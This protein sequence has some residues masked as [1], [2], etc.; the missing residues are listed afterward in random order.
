MIEW[1]NRPHF[2]DEGLEFTCTGCGQCCTGAPGVVFVNE[3]EI[4]DIAR[5]LGLSRRRFVKECLYRV[6]NGYSIRERDNYDCWFFKDNRCSIYPVRP[7]QCRTY[8]FWYE[9]LRSK[10]A[11][12]KTCRDCPGAGEGRLYPREEILRLAERSMDLRDPA[13][14][15]VET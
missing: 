1:K 3:L 7:T 15:R 8:P 5:H 13:A 11:W 4:G 6:R 2:F 12:R 14:P 10:A 9:N